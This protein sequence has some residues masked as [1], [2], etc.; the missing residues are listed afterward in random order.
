[1][2]S[3]SENELE[4]SPPE[5]ED[6]HADSSALDSL[7]DDADERP[8][9]VI[10][11][12]DVFGSDTESDEPSPQSSPPAVSQKKKTDHKAKKRFV[13]H[14]DESDLGQSDQNSD[15]GSDDAHT[16][17][18]AKRSSKDAPRSKVAS[19]RRTL[20]SGSDLSD[21]DGGAD[22]VQAHSDRREPA[23]SE[24]DEGDNFS[25]R[26]IQRHS[27]S[28]PDQSNSEMEN[29]EQSHKRPTHSGRTRVSR[30]D[31]DD[32]EDEDDEEQQE[33]E[34]AEDQARE[35]EEEEE[36]GRGRGSHASD[37]NQSEGGD[38][39]QEPDETRIAVDFPLIRA[40]LGKEMYLVKMP[41][42]L[43]VET[44]PFDP[45]FYEDELDEDEVL[46][47]EGRTRL[48]LK[49]ENTIRWRY[50][51]TPEGELV[52]ESNARIVRWSDGS[53]SLHLGDEIFDIH[54]V[55]IHSDYNYLFIREGSGLQEVSTVY[56]ESES[57]SLSDISESKSRKRARAKI[58]DDEEEADSD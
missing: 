36:E 40:D 45:N 58:I 2:S 3:D 13:R 19:N 8:Q 26:R 38:A 25:R 17:S 53:L 57:E 28:S 41:N 20:D 55:D 48:K 51:Q 56:S 15:T 54:K 23:D 1:M 24:E 14:S 33:E 39:D 49:V 21:A 27:S 7:S 12:K 11:Q 37:G 46:D 42:F 6:E 50:G 43:S 35:E 18:A 31:D 5:R 34:E 22:N 4:A 44:R 29:D 47:E 32:E 16:Q 52:H 30:G 10:T 9:N